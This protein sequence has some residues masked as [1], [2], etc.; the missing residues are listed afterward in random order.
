M[1]YVLWLASLLGVSRDD[2]EG[3]FDRLSGMVEVQPL[4]PR[5]PIHT[6][7]S[8][9]IREWGWGGGGV[10]DHQIEQEFNGYLSS[11]QT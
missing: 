1:Q 4:K 3:T 2:V 5:F 9:P 8:E 7:N 11:V 10:V 6:I